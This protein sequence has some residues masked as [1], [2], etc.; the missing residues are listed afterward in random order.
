MDCAKR[1][2]A[3]GRQVLARES[4]SWQGEEGEA[5]GAGS[6]PEVGRWA[7]VHKAGP[8]CWGQGRGR[9]WP[10]LG[11]E[12]VEEGCFLIP[13]APPPQGGAR[14]KGPPGGWWG[15]SRTLCTEA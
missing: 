14:D 11:S 8:W 6:R 12:G 9:G 5:G 1:T 7:C 15:A 3:P 2:S 10:R 13:W 4:S